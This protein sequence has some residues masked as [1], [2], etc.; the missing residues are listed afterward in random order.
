M[1]H[2]LLTLM[3][4]MVT[5]VAQG[6][7]ETPEFYSLD[8]ADM[9]ES[10]DYPTDGWSTLGNGAKPSE[11]AQ[12][13]FN[14]DGSGP[15]YMLLS[16][17][18]M[19]MAM[20]N[21]E[22]P[23][24]Q[25]AD[26]W[27]ISPEIEV[28]Y[29]NAALLFTACAF[30][31][32]GQSMTVGLN[33]FK[34]YVS[35]SGAAKEDFKELVL[36]SGLRGSASAYVTSKK[37]VA[38]INGYEGK[39][40]RIAF[41]VNGRNVGLTG[42]ANLKMGQYILE[43]TN[44][45]PEVADLG[46]SVDVDVNVGLKTPVECGYIDAVLALDGQTVVE[47]EY[48]RTFGSPTSYTLMMQHMIFESAIRMDSEEPV[49]YTL[50][51]TPRFEGALPSVVTGYVS[52]PGA[53]YPANV[54]IE[55]F[56]ATGCG[57]CPRGTASLEYYLHTYPGGDGK[58][59]AIPIAI[60][61]YMN[62]ADPMNEGVEAYL[63]AVQ[64]LNGSSG[65]PAAIFNRSTRGLDPSYATEVHKQM[66]LPSYNQV[67][68]N[69]V[70]VPEYSDEVSAAGG[71]V[72]VDFSVRNGFNASFRELNASVVLIENDVVGYNSGYVQTN[73]FSTYDESAIISHVGSAIAPF[74]MPYARGGEFGVEMIPPTLMKYQHVARG[75]YPDVVGQTLNTSWESDKPYDYQI[76]FTVPPTV[77]NMANT[78]VVVL[79]TEAS[80][81]AIVASDIAGEE[82]Y[83]VSGIDGIAA[84][85]EVSVRAEDGSIIVK[86]PAGA[87][88]RVY[89]AAGMQLGSS[90]ASA[91]G[92]AELRIA[93]SGVAIVSIS[94][95][96]GNVTRKVTL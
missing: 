56:T 49:K 77:T 54:V 63:A 27:L 50:T 76:T 91:A 28:P 32:M 24:G 39:K 33:T 96:E 64:G 62:Y 67:T 40:V 22:Y 73:Y 38:P 46:A 41:V 75:I 69:K 1:K 74:L 19:T 52:T 4:L 30:A 42:F 59:R 88:I 85:S 60:H 6:T 87:G 72:T 25:E 21:T 51:L 84:D 61:S 16:Y 71:E 29:D 18:G 95:A 37:L 90:R 23:D 65:L 34:V 80:S 44:Y 83:S 78:Q 36:D 35:D 57:Y 17:D 45:T 93:H 81:Q 12:K 68:I 53:T 82:K 55:E 20:A 89:D 7:V 9:A 11:A 66:E 86:A 79:V 5:L 8:F 31:D 94:T 10:S 70:T 47:S 3:V 26:Q 43:A 13:F 48:R 14:A 2:F 58:G 92:E 15:Y